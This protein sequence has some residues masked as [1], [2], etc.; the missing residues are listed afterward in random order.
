MN[1]PKVVVIGMG[2]VGFPLACAIARSG[3]Y[4]ITG[5]DIDEKKISKINSRISP[6]EDKQAEMDIKEFPFRATNDETILRGAEYIAI[7]VPTPVDNNKSP[8]L[9]PVVKSTETVSRNLTKTPRQHIILE[10]TVNPGVTE[11]TMLPILQRTGLRGGLDF[12]LAHCPERINPG[13]PNYNVYNIP[14]NVGGMTKEGTKKVADFYRK[15][16]HPTKVTE[17]GSI[18]AAEAT[19]IFENTFRDYNIALANWFATYCD[20]EGIDGVEVLRGA[21]SK[22][23][24]FMAHSSG[25]GVGGHCIAVDPY[26]LIERAESLGIDASPLITAREMNNSM[27]AYTANK[28]FRALSKKGIGVKGTNVGLLGLSYK[29]NI[30]DMRESPAL[31]IRHILQ[32]NGAKVMAYDPFCNGNSTAKLDEVLESCP[33][34]IL[35][36]NHNAFREID[37]WGNVQVIIDG[38]N[39][40]NREAIEAK[41]IYYEG[42]GRGK[43]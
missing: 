26:Y 14:R 29:G 11:E 16:I 43:A 32:E 5:Y 27:P 23:F 2:Y 1:K 41:N 19:K 8:D 7:C 20:A 28:L 6:V 17:L 42:I 18:R 24:G 36:T 40:L 37:E 39:C 10:S 3:A 35:A 4:D 38:R 9:T 33:G 22:P 12:E 21:S 34:V 30:G 13:D 31:E 15:V 25:C